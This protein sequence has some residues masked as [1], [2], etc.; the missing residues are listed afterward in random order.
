MGPGKLKLTSNRSTNTEPERVRDVRLATGFKPKPRRGDEAIQVTSVPLSIKARD[1]M[2][3]GTGSPAPTSGAMD[4][5]G[6]PTMTSKSNPL[7]L[8]GYDCVIL[9]APMEPERAVPLPEIDAP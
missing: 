9:Y 4:L 1:L 5:P 8:I 2:G 3:A 7:A 6:N